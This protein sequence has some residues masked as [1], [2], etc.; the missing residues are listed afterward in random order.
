[1]D[2]HAPF[3]GPA[4]WDTETPV[5]DD[6]V[7][8]LDA[9]CL[10]ELDRAAEEL[11]ANPLPVEALTAGLIDMPACARAMAKARTAVAT[12][13]GFAIVDR[14]P[15]DAYDEATFV[16]LYWLLF[17]M[18]ARPV[19]QK[20]DGTM[21][22]DVTDSGRVDA[23]GNGVRASKTKKGQYYHTDNAFNLPPE[24]V[25]LL[26]VQPAK[27]GGLSGLVSLQ[28]VVNMLLAEQPWLVA[29]LYRPFFFDRQDE[30]P[31]GDEC[32]SLHPI[33]EPGDGGVN[34]RFNRRLLNYGY[35]LAD[36]AMD[37]E[38]RDALAAFFAML[39]R[40][41]LDKVFTFERGQIQI[42]NNRRLG[43]RREAYDDWPEPERKR[44]LIRLWGRETGRP[45]YL[46]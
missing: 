20:W 13:P 3:T 37:D 16:R 45:F 7:I 39:D 40:P 30:H 12:G 29:R 46:G 25:A 22:Y 11:R 23:A 6:G 1:M 24:T 44:R 8:A 34:V 41:G 31:P 27:R 36:E 42:I 4:A 5:P 2:G 17:S 33:L 32:L 15:L 26:C 28:T 19:A 43:H 38:T 35:E 10:A 18:I 9:E 14:L 21:V